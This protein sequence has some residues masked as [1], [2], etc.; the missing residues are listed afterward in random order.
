MESQIS[1]PSQ[2]ENATALAEKINTNLSPDSGEQPKAE[3]PVFPSQ[4]EASTQ[5]KDK[6]AEVQASREELESRLA[7][8]DSAIEA[9]NRSDAARLGEV[10]ADKEVHVAPNGVVLTP[11]EYQDAI[12]RH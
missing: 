4:A 1:A 3:L 12:S 11:S 6:E 8:S 10:A 7:K 2:Q 5:L 9:Q